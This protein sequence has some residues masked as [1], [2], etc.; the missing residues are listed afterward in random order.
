MKSG[1]RRIKFMEYLLKLILNNSTDI[2]KEDL[3]TETEDKLEELSRESEVLSND[4]TKL[5]HLI[6]CLGEDL[7]QL[8]KSDKSRGEL[9]AGFFNSELEV[10]NC[11]HGL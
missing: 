7:K 9:D 10:W 5:H 1:S 11:F 8:S 2:S 6:I 3:E 4:M